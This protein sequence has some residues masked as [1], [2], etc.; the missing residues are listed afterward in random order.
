MNRTGTAHWS[1]DL[2][3]GNGTVSTQTTTLHDTPYSF[4]SRF[5]AGKGT[6]PEELL[7]AAH[8]GCFSMA[9]SAV[10]GGHN[11]KPD[12]ID[13]KAT[14]TLDKDGDG[15]GFSITRVHLAV[16]ATIP[17]ATDEDFQSAAQDAKSSCPVSKLFAGAEITM[18]AKLSG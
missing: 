6:N 10:L 5:E 17:G 16:T 15:D 14:V 18:D 4:A 13:T 3:T 8:A 12:A 9:L 7:A 2:K 11:M 1:G